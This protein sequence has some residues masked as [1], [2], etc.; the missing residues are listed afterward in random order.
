[1]TYKNYQIFCHRKFNYFQKD[2]TYTFLP[3]RVGQKKT[4][5]LIIEF[6]NFTV[7]TLKTPQEP[8]RISSFL[9]LPTPDSLIN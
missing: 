2:I 6:R 1:M 4:N 7:K 8:R 9:Y 3:D 5:S